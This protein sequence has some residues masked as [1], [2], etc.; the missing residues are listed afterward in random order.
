[1]GSLHPARANT[2]TVPLP[3]A[4][5]VRPR[6]G[7]DDVQAV[8]GQPAP[9]GAAVLVRPMRAR[10]RSLARPIALAIALVLATGSLVSGSSDVLGVDPG[11]GGLPDWWAAAQPIASD[12]SVLAGGR[13]P[14]RSSYASGHPVASP[15]P[16]NP[17]A[18]VGGHIRGP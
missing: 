14:G 16:S 4:I 3:A 17:R 12:G 15:Q 8:E 18:A 1:M 2:S 13:S 5:H 6:V 7:E 11:E 9:V 10:T